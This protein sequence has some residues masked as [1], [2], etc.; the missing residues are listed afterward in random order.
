MFLARSGPT[1]WELALEVEEKW[2]SGTISG[3][4]KKVEPVKQTK[5]TCLNNTKI[6]E[7]QKEEALRVLLSDGLKAY[8]ALVE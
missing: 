6:T 2:I 4:P 5:F 7:T 8:D 3:Q 1:L